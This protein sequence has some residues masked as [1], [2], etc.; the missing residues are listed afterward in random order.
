MKEPAKQVLT[1]QHRV[2]KRYFYSVGLLSLLWLILFVNNHPQWIQQIKEVLHLSPILQANDDSFYN[3]RIDPIF[4]KY[5]AACHNANKDKG[6][7]RLD[8][9]R[10][11]SFSGRS[12]A[13][14]TASNNNLLVARMS[15]PNTD[16]LAMPP[17][18]RERHTDQELALIKLWLAKGGS[19]QLTEAD[20]PDAPAK[21]R[22][23]K[24]KDIDWQQIS[25]LRAPDKQQVETLQASFPHTIQYLARTSHMLSINLSL[26]TPS[27]T[28][29][30]LAKL[31][32]LSTLITEL[33]LDTTEVSD[34]AI[35]TLRAMDQLQE[36]KLTQT[37]IT[38]NTLEA[39]LDLPN[40]QK[41]FADQTIITPEIKQQYA[42]QGIV[43]ISAQW[44]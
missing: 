5:C 38:S 43:L 25:L 41:V 44:R 39:L 6:R 16:R 10:Q 24:F 23:I 2:A 18:G 40:I 30:E 26:H 4:E 11:L 17:F 21:A 22:V 15:L 8:S 9:F 28:D 37:N 20:F 14:L 33:N 7:L 42:E 36:I 29:I 12:Q 31:A 3:S 13:D 1:Q 27:I 19:G 32:P 34:A 35:K